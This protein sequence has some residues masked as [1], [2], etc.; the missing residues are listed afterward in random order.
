MEPNASCPIRPTEFVR[1]GSVSRGTVLLSAALATLVAGLVLL[2]LLGHKPLAEWDEGIYA[3]VSREMLSRGWL[4][5]H[6]NGQVWLEKPPLLLWITAIFF[7]LFGVHEFWARA[8]S[9][10]SGVATVGLLHGWLARKTNLLMAWFSSVILLGTF[11]FLHV[12]HMGEMDVLLSLGCCIAL[13]GLTEV[14]QRNANG[15]YFFWSGFAIALMTKGAAS[16]VLPIAAVLF[17]ALQRWGWVRFGKACWLGLLLFLLVVL[18]WHLYMFHLFG[19]QFLAEYLGLH[20]LTRATHQIE[21]HATHWWYYFGVL[22]ASAAP[23]VLLFPA[24]MLDCWR[25]NEL[26]AWVVFSVVVV[27]FFTVVQTRLPHYIAPAYP[28]LTVLAAVYLGN[29]LGPL[30]AQRRAPSFWIKV[31][32]ASVAI[33]IASALLTSHARKSLHTAKLSDGT[34]LPDN[35]DSI[36]LLRDAFSHPKPITGPLLLWREGRI[37]SIATDV[38]YSQRTV[39]QVQLLPVP[40]GVSTDKYFFQPEALSGAVGSESRL[41]LL[42]KVLVRQIPHEFTYTPIQSGKTVELGTIALSR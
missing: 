34:V 16:V 4:V 21:G 22:L 38:F 20:V 42:D 32:L 35:K 39:Q 29:Q 8:G 2:P 27:G 1:P 10:L 37:M 3:E 30:V 12:C 9:A 6:W 40:A 28:A 7:K 33:F 5:P 41:I 26:R 11:G 15:W 31:V 13:I 17:I 14:D 18:P 19:N 25:R 36:L 23:F 24:S